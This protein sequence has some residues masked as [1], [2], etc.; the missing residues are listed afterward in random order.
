MLFFRHTFLIE[1]VDD[2]QALVPGC[3]PPRMAIISEVA[4]IGS[5]SKLNPEMAPEG[6]CDT[7]GRCVEVNRK[8]TSCLPHP[9]LL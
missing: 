4:V 8:G 9:L 3:V 6:L 1:A 7:R 2:L 5:K